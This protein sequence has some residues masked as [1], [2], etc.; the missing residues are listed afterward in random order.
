MLVC[1]NVWCAG[2][3]GLQLVGL[4]DGL[5]AWEPVQINIGGLPD[6]ADGFSIKQGKLVLEN[7]DYGWENWI[8]MCSP[9]PFVS[10]DRC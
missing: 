7:E 6:F 8:S 1:G 10:S 3:S 2:V 9:F 5:L 4:T